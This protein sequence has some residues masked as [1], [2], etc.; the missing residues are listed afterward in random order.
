M[1]EYPMANALKDFESLNPKRSAPSA[2][3]KKPKI[4]DIFGPNISRTK[5]KKNILRRELDV[6]A[7]KIVGNASCC[8]GQGVVESQSS[9][10]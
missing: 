8:L 10:N 5:P 2:E 7:V 4:P 1:K 9:A 6:P 3:I